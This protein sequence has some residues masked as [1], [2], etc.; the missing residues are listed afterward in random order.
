MKDTSRTPPC[1]KDTSLDTPLY[2]GNHMFFSPKKL[3]IPKYCQVLVV[4]HVQ[5]YTLYPISLS[6]FLKVI[7]P[8]ISR[9]RQST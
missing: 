9:I 5:D 1:T 7:K 3:H 4:E 8:S 2:E 6:H